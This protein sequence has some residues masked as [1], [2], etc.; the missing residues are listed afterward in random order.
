MQ[1][2]STPPHMSL[3]P[4][5]L[6]PPQWSSEGVSLTK[7]VYGAF[8][9]NFQGVQQFLSSTASI[10]LALEPWAGGLVWDWD[11]LSLKYSS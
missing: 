10:F 7:S 8:K 2:N 3:V 6:L 5:S 4:F 9:R 1:D 11:P